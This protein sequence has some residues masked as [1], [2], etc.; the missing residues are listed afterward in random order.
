MHNDIQTFPSGNTQLAVNRTIENSFL[1]T[2]LVQ[3]SATLFQSYNSLAQSVLSTL[4]DYALYPL[5]QSYASTQAD[6]STQ[7]NSILAFILSPQIVSIE[8]EFEI[9]MH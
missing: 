4:D 8:L 6:Y 1:F 9:F 3:L 7:T 2:S 5:N